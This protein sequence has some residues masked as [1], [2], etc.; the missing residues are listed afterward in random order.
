MNPKDP[1]PETLYGLMKINT[2]NTRLHEDHLTIIYLLYCIFLEMLSQSEL[3][4]SKPLLMVVVSLWFV[5]LSDDC[6][7]SAAPIQPP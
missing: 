7:L 1:N 5:M 2:H 4:E 6:T 3:L